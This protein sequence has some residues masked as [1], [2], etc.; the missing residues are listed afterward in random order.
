MFIIMTNE[1]MAWFGAGQLNI[2][3]FIL[4]FVYIFYSCNLSRR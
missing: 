4:T 2:M 3:L 1:K